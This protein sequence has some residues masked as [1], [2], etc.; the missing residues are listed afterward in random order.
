M[1]LSLLIGLVSAIAGKAIIDNQVDKSR[2][3]HAAIDE[4]EKLCEEESKNYTAVK[5]PT[6]IQQKMFDLLLMNAFE[7]SD[8]KET[9]PFSDWPHLTNKNAITATRQYSLFSWKEYSFFTRQAMYFHN[10]KQGVHDLIYYDGVESYDP[11]TKT[12]TY[13]KPF[14]TKRITVSKNIS[15]WNKF[16]QDFVQQIAHIW[17]MTDEDDTSVLEF[18]FNHCD[19]FKK[20]LAFFKTGRIKNHFVNRCSG[21]DAVLRENF[22]HIQIV[23]MKDG[24]IELQYWRYFFYH[25]EDI[26][27][28]ECEANDISEELYC[29]RDEI[30]EVFQETLYDLFGV[31]FQKE[32]ITFLQEP[33]FTY[34]GPSM[35]DRMDDLR[36]KAETCKEFVRDYVE[37]NCK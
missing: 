3:A 13:N 35:A 31:R 19:D 2:A 5:R 7:D 26:A 6:I 4:G 14:S 12:L 30:A 10:A 25:D 18:C 24:K 33:D 23:S 20:A 9:P 17:K 28:H 21:R 16:E 22:D 34:E 8:K 29:L 37:K 11:T 1:A 15:H 27:D 32:N 36:G